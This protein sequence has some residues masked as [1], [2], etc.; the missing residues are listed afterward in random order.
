LWRIFSNID[1][2][3]SQKTIAIEKIGCSKSGTDIK[4]RFYNRNYL[5]VKMGRLRNQG[6]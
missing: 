3:I 4:E 5:N 1:L 2:K 6:A